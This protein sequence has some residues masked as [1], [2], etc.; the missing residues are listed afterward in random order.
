MIKRHLFLRNCLTLI[1]VVIGQLVFSQDVPIKIK[2]TEEISNSNR[3]ENSFYSSSDGALFISTVSGNIFKVSNL[4]SNPVV[5]FFCNNPIGYLTDIAVDKY[6]NLYTTNGFKI[7]FYDGLSCNQVSEINF[8]GSVMLSFDVLNNMYCSESSK[9]YRSSETN[10]NDFQVWKD[11]STGLAG[12]D[13]V[14]LN[15]KLYLAWIEDFNFLLKEITVDENF[16]YISHVDLFELPSS[17]FGLASEL[18]NLYG[19]TPQ[20]LFRI[21]LSNGQIEN[22][23]TNANVDDEWYGATS[24]NE[25]IIPN[26]NCI[27]NNIITPNNDD[28]NDSFNLSCFE[29]VNKLEIYN[30]WGRKVFEKEG[31]VNECYGQNMNSVRLP[32][33]TYFYTITF[34][35][36]EYKTGWVYIKE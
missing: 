9:V 22:V 3:T 31:Y 30:R 12:G 15:G 1:L 11:F 36:G 13:C 34:D 26:Q 17:T 20:Q 27:V 10:Y 29:K 18:G 24:L 8:L 4:D 5:N 2:E 28:F 33:S 14:F 16:N 35:N 32:E 23:L 7:Q 25:A 6:Q 19:I 21:N